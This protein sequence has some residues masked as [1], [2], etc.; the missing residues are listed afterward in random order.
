MGAGAIGCELLKNFSMIVL[1]C[2]DGGSI[3]VTDM[4]I[5]EKSNLNWQ[6]LFRPWDI[7]VNE[8]D[9]VKLLHFSPFSS[10]LSYWLRSFLFPHFLQFLNFSLQFSLS[11][12]IHW[13]LT[14]C[15]WHFTSLP[16]LFFLWFLVTAYMRLQKLGY[17]WKA[18]IKVRVIFC[19]L[20][21]SLYFYHAGTRQ[22]FDSWEIK[23]IENFWFFLMQC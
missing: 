17:R 21:V 7:T 23:K 12:D 4:D 14:S 5:I 10:Y 15:I 13:V 1:G 8:M 19:L 18:Y 6:F 22:Y 11:A 3:T 20:S 2:E 9:R 16:T